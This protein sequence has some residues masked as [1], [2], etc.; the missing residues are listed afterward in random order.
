MA[1]VQQRTTVR[2]QWIVTLLTEPNSRQADAGILGRLN[3]SLGKDWRVP[4]HGVEWKIT[5]DQKEKGPW[6]TPQITG[7]SNDVA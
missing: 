5:C 4:L 3:R 6:R 1:R 2:C 7:E